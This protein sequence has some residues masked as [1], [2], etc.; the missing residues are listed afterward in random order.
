ALELTDLL[1]GELPPLPRAEPGVPQRAD[2]GPH[3]PPDRVPDRGAHAAHLAVAPLVDDDPQH[4][5]REQRRLRGRRDAVLQLHALAQPPQRP[6]PRVALDL[7]HVLLLDAEAR[8]G[9]PVR[10]GPVVGEQQEALGVAVEAADRVHPGLG[11]HELDHGRPSLRVVRGGDHTGGLVEQ[12]VDEVGTHPDGH[13]VDGDLVAVHVDPRPQPGGAAVDRHP[14][15]GDELLAGPAAADPRARQHLLEALA[16][17]GGLAHGSRSSSGSQGR[18]SPLD[19]STTTS[20]SPPARTSPPSPPPAGPPPRPPPASPASPP[21]PSP[22]SMRR[23]CSRSSTTSASGM[24]SPSEGSS[25]SEF[26]PRRSRNSWVVPNSAA[27]PGPTSRPTSSMYP[28]CW[29]VRITPSTFTP[30]IAAPCARELGCLY[31]TIARVSSA[32]ADNLAAW[33]LST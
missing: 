2:P 25:S 4:P 1:G 19:R 23:P 9:E 15:V 16:P 13:A 28:R 31:A 26:R 10:E 7:R 3:Q 33:P 20:S 24:K 27:W 5:R 8:V 29:R 18:S 11:R 17:R 30:R 12:V 32:A 21:S 22:S 14:S 6:S